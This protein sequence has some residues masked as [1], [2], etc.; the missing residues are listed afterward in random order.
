MSA[1]VYQTKRRRTPLKSTL[2]VHSYEKLKFHRMFYFRHLG[3]SWCVHKEVYH[4][5]FSLYTK[6]E[7][8][9]KF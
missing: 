6:F 9:D 7:G 8:K 2:D 5:S 4:C 3:P 1:F